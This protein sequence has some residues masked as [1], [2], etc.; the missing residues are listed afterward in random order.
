M[1]VKEMQTDIGFKRNPVIL[2]A[3]DEPKVR[4]SLSDILR[5]EDY[6]VIE[7]SDGL[8]VIDKITPGSVDV[9]LL[10]INMPGLDGLEIT[11][12]LK[13]D[14]QLKV[15]P[16]VIVTG[17]ND[18]KLRIE[19]LK[20]GADDFLVK[21]PHFAELIARVRSLLK[22][23]AYNDHMMTYQKELEKQVASRTE[24]LQSALARIKTASLDTI[25]RLSRAAEYKDEDTATHIQRMSSYAAA[26]AKEL[27]LPDSEIELILYTS[28]MHDIGKIGIPDQ[29]LLKKG[30]LNADEW[31]QMKTHTLIGG[32]I[33]KGSSSDFL[34]KGRVIALTHHEKWDGSGYPEGLTGPDIPIEGRICAIADVFDALTTKRPYKEPFS[35]DK[36]VDIIKEGRGSHFDPEVADAFLN[37]FE[38]IIKIMKRLNNAGEVG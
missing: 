13:A 2:V 21:P 25:H 29:I 36:A 10:D 4:Q 15:I 33:L 8:A 28:S 14:E 17:Q 24:Q 9:I 19:A 20:A 18:Q 1:E 38:N 32:E 6:D 12:K 16:I 3:D 35:I 31:E 30:K 7:A 22:V 26:V 23:K 37:N 27:G 11:K 34:K 5:I